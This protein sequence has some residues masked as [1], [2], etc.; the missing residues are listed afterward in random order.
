[1]ELERACVEGI[2]GIQEAAAVGVSSPGGGPEQLVLFLVPRSPGAR[3]SASEVKA[4]CQKA[5]R[6]KLNPLF[7]VE[8]VRESKHPMAVPPAP[9]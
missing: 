4:Q 3:G 6:L 1:M 9:L 5:I 2:S 7:K 8:K